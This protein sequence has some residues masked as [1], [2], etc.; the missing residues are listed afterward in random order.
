MNTTNTQEIELEKW[1]E[2]YELK[3]IEKIRLIAEKMSEELINEKE[4]IKD[5]RANL[6]LDLLD[7]RKHIIKF[8]ENKGCG[9]ITVTLQFMNISNFCQDFSKLRC[10][11]MLEG[12]EHNFGIV[13]N[14]R[15]D[16]EK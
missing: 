3:D 15:R 5:K 9:F 12:H 4:E 2:L 11:W 16:E 13:A 14:Y 7:I 8:Y 1:L 10:D 6:Y